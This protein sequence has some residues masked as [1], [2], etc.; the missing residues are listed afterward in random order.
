MPSFGSRKHH[1]KQIESRPLTSS[2]LTTGR[3]SYDEHAVLLD[4]TGT[5]NGKRA[6]P[7]R[8]QEKTKRGDNRGARETKKRGVTNEE[9]V[10][11]EGEVTLSRLNNL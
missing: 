11:R 10:A 1:H 3:T 7:S 6:L 5:P 4:R 9:S 8:H 2:L